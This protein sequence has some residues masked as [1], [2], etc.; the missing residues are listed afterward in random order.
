MLEPHEDRRLMER[1]LMERRIVDNPL[2]FHCVVRAKRARHMRQ[3]E[4][5]SGVERRAAG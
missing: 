4:R 1:R 5:R 3:H 2:C